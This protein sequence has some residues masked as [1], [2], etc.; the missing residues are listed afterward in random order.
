MTFWTKKLASAAERLAASEGGRLNETSAALVINGVFTDSSQVAEWREIV[1]AAATEN[2]HI[3]LRDIANEAVS[4][5]DADAGVTIGQVMRVRITKGT[6]GLYRFFTLEGF[7]A[8]LTD[9]ELMRNARLVLIAGDFEPFKSEACEFRPWDDTA[10]AISIP[11]PR[12]GDEHGVDA[13]KLVRDTTG[14]T[15]PATIAFWLPTS[16][17]ITVSPEYEVWRRAATRELLPLMAA[18]IWAEGDSVKLVVSGTRKRTLSLGDT[19]AISADAFPPLASAVTWVFE[20]TREAEVRHTLLAKRIGTEWPTDDPTWAAGLPSVLGVA[21]DGAKSDYKAHLHE[22]TSETLKALTDLRKALNEEAGKVVERT[23]G[24]SAN[25]NRDLAFAIGAVAVRLVSM[26]GEAK[27]V[28]VSRWFLLSVAIW[29]AA[30][31]RNSLQTNRSFLRL[32]AS[33]R[34]SWHRRVHGVLARNDFKRLVRMPLRDA[35]RAYAEAASKIV[36]IYVVIIGGLI[37]LAGWDFIPYIVNSFVLPTATDKQSSITDKAVENKIQAPDP[38]K[39]LP[40][41]TPAQPTPTTIS[42]PTPKAEPPRPPLAVSPA[43]PTVRPYRRHPSRC[44]GA[45][46]RAKHD[47]VKKRSS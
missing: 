22:K 35:A 33:M 29:L 19:N 17:P 38:T 46:E 6:G 37:I 13:R 41:P 9:S 8:G 12:G 14:K 45:G 39:S 47:P 21:L 10:A 40:T 15:L 28:A 3:A 18:E 26:L 23:Q 7:R 11:E 2:V 27:Y 32:Q 4:L 24:L 1:A 20:L 43:S 30:S 44:G 34:A 36:R 5:N 31:L 25:L 16:A 42:P